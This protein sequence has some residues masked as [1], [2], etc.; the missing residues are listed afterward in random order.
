Q[1]LGVAALCRA[2]DAAAWWARA[3]AGATAAADDADLAAACGSATLRRL[4]PNNNRT[5][6]RT[7]SW[8][9][10]PTLGFMGTTDFEDFLRS[11]KNFERFHSRM[12]K[13]WRVALVRA[14]QKQ[15]GKKDLDESI[16]R[17]IEEQANGRN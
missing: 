14:V 6:N 13:I 3:A 15:L 17:A 5:S 8:I 7:W 10:T 2:V 9:L 11:T 12:R 1:R 16:T 4:R